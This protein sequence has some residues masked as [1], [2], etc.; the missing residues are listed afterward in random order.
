MTTDLEIARSVEP[1]PIGDVAAD[2]GIAPEHVEPWGRQVAKVSLDAIAGE[3]KARYVLVTAT[4]PTP[5]GEGKTTTSVGLAQAMHRLG[6]KSVVTLRQPS[7]GPT[8]GIKGGAAGGGHSQVIPMEE[9]NLHLTGDFHAVTAANNMLAAL[10]DAH[11]Y[12]G[13]QLSLVP[14]D[15]TWRRVV[16]VNDRALRD[17]VLGLGRKVDGVPRQTGFDITAASEVM[18]ILG[19]A[20]DLE[21]LRIRLGRIV[22]GY[23]R[24]QKPVT[25]EQ[26]KGA[27]AMAVLLRDALEPNLLQTLE[28]SAAL[29]HTGP[30]AN[31][32]HGNSSVVADELA[33]RVADVCIT[34]A[35]F[36]TDIGAEKFFNIKCRASG[37]APDV[38]VIV[39]TVR[40]MKM[41]SGN[42]R[43]RPGRPLPP[44]MLEENPVEVTD[45]AANLRRHIGIIRRHGVTPV[46]AINKFATDHESEH[47]AIA[48]VCEAEGVAWA[49]ADP[50]A[51]GGAGCEDLARTVLDAEASNFELLYPDDLPVRNKIERIATE[52]YG[53]DGVNFESAA[54]KDIDRYEDLG[55][56]HLPICMAKTHLSLS[57]DPRVHGAPTG[58]ML[59]IRRVQASIGAGFLLPL[60]GE[61]RRM[62]GLA[63]HPSAF[64]MDLLP[65]GTIVGLS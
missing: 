27:G 10:I 40:S 25:A 5:L 32:A 28:G 18:A 20:T 8:F 24:H 15:I 14:H 19:L 51:G 30:F 56:G 33:V 7:Q 17:M 11:L 2:L 57:H 44:A 41:H 34:E 52:V 54:Q 4:S 13:N 45:G 49:V 21:D 55:W 64:D 47:Q 46:V 39:T 3:K 59:P 58:W 29:V 12:H 61:V 48:A 63:S 26:V 16:D 9:M 50:H 22:I 31:I 42:H 35:G 36:G 23:D 62:P 1:R 65:D 53:A 60:A 37:L 6:Q 38:A 43:I